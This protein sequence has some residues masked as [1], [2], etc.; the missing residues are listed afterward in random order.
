MTSKTDFT[1]TEWEVVREAPPTA[2]MVAATASSGGS[3]R[4][5]WALAK[6]FGEARQHHGQSELLDALVAERP[7]PKRYHSPAELEEKGLA[8]L[9]KAVELVE[10]KATPEELDAY[11]QFTIGVA[12]RVA[13]A[14]KEGGDSVSS[15]EQAA[16]AKI[17]AALNAG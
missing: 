15:P 2:G 3:F 12:E 8:L 5:S 1:D 9:R 11:R 7:H 17:T 6:A 10:Q 13:E 14:H 4:E 16:L